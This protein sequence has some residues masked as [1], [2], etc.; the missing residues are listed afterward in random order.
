MISS[1]TKA[2]LSRLMPISSATSASLAVLSLAWK[3]CLMPISAAR[4]S[5]ILDLRVISATSTPS[6]IRQFAP[7]PSS[8]QK[9]WNFTPSSL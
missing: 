1:P 9:V 4:T 2:M 7:K 3:T 6:I 8:W 5:T